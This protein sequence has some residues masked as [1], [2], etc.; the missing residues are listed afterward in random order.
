MPCLKMKET[1]IRKGQYSVHGKTVY[2]MILLKILFPLT[3]LALAQRRVSEL[4]E[5]ES[6]GYA[7][8]L[9]SWAD[10]TY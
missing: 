3:N 4:L 2:F 8:S 10:D 1:F 9:P 6:L 5:G 7:K